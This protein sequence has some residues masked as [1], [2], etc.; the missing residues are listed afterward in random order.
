[1]QTLRKQAQYDKTFDTQQNFTLCTC[2]I[3]HFLNLGTHHIAETFSFKD[4]HAFIKLTSII[5][6]NIKC[7]FNLSG[8]WRIT[9]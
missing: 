8:S 1:M 9:P 2:Y 6:R 5:S 4:F 3:F 7:R